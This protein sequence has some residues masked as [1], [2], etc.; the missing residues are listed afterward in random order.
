M[1]RADPDIY[2]KLDAPTLTTVLLNP[3]L[4]EEAHKAALSALSKRPIYERT[5]P[6]I[7]TLRNYIAHHSRYAPKVAEGVIAILGT[8]PDADA[9]VAMLEVLPLMLKSTLSGAAPPQSV[10]E[11]YY[12]AL[13]TR[14]RE[15]DLQV[16]AEMLPTFDAL[17]LAA[18]ILDPAAVP[19]E[20]IEPWTLL[21]RRP[22][23]DRTNAIF[24]VILGATRSGA[25]DMNVRQA[26]DLLEKSHDGQAFEDGLDVLAEQWA[27]ARKHNRHNH[28]AGLEAALSLID[29]R[30]RSAAERI[31]G[32]RP[33]AP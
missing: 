7:R 1:A 13:I 25:L 2:D 19:L 27:L 12:G 18:A 30:P 24:T 28:A 16:W 26:I 14:Q 23:P 29:R 5:E 6:L 22:E 21:D 31:V 4:G 10:R 32:K 20:D 3:D 33:W 11:Y 8:D 17:T 9:T 15:D